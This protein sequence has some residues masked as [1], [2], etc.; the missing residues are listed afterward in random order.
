V[1]PVTV[2]PH[3]EENP[4][5][6]GRAVLVGPSL[7]VMPTLP[8]G[9]EVAVEL[10]AL[11]RLTYPPPQEAT[12]LVAVHEAGLKAPNSL[13]TQLLGFLDGHLIW[14]GAL[15]ET[16][17]TVLSEGGGDPRILLGESIGTG[18]R[19]F[20]VVWPGELVL[21][22]TGGRLGT[23][24]SGERPWVVIGE[25]AEQDILAAPLNEAGNPKWYTPVL[26][27]EEVLISGSSKDAQLELPHV[28]SLPGSLP[29]VGVVA[30]SA[31]DRILE[32]VTAYF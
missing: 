4:P 16:H 15:S 28:W 2:Q 14:A 3:T 8:P 24:Y 31:R 6:P 29:S 7:C 19:L 32:E 10:Q 26:R 27:R 21:E 12:L 5:T 20:T 18:T 13:H 11:D 17:L 22:A 1:T 25:T 30:P 9:T 23:I